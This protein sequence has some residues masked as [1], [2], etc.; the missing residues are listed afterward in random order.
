M[1]GKSPKH[2]RAHEAAKVASGRIS[3]R[4]EVT[5]HKEPTGGYWAEVPKLPGCY[6]HGETLA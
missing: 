1:A 5:V 6:S 3:A 4:L 2:G